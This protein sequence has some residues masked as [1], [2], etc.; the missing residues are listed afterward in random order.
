MTDC[1][2]PTICF[3]VDS[4]YLAVVAR[5]EEKRIDIPNV[6]G[7]REPQKHKTQASRIVWTPGDENGRLGELLPP[8]D[9]GGNPRQIAQ[10]DELFTIRISAFDVDDPENELAQYRE[11]RRVYDLLFSAIHASAFGTFT[12]LDSSWDLSKNERRHGEMVIITASVQ[13][14]IFDDVAATAPVDTEGDVETSV[15]D[16][17]EKTLVPVP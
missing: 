2:K 12:Y 3:A 13:A 15:E 17:T 6:F 9:V 5:F 14:P 1:D 11:A 10:L 8:R 4:L 16:L 7:W